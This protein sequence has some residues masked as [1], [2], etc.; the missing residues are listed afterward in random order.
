MSHLPR[1]GLAA[2]LAA[3]PLTAGDGFHVGLSVGAARPGQALGE[4]VDGRAG[5]ALGLVALAGMNAT[6]SIRPRID[7]LAFPAHA[8]VTD[9]PYGQNALRETWTR[10]LSA[11]SAGTD[12]VYRPGGGRRGLFV[13]L[14]VA[15]FRWETRESWRLTTPSSYLFTDSGIHSSTSIRFG[16]AGGVGYRLGDH[17]SVEGRY[18]KSSI[19]PNDADTV[20]VLATYLF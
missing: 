3:A 16:C 5:L 13:D 2:L 20:Q 11:F 6:W 15:A 8:I 18:V 7:W 14:G 9:R 1:L 19:G 17:V 12:L 4:A 10:R